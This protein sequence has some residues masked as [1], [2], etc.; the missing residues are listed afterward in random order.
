MLTADP[1]KQHDPSR[2]LP[3]KGRL[4]TN[5]IALHQELCSVT[6]RASRLS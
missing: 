3:S 2:I 1:S 5:N 4:C 6:Y